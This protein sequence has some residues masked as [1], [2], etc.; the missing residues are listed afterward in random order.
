[1]AVL[2][3]ESAVVQ[4]ETKITC[5]CLSINLMVVV[6]FQSIPVA[7]FVRR[8]DLCNLP[9]LQCPG[10]TKLGRDHED[11]LQSLSNLAVLLK[12]QGHLA[13]SEPLFREVLEKSLGAQLQRFQWDFGQWIWSHTCCA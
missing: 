3:K 8:C 10:E 9:L 1:M 12:D 11:T 7:V 13:E 2:A 4:M 6:G 5:V